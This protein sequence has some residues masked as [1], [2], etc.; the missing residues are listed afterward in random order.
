MNEKFPDMHGMF[1]NS[2]REEGEEELE[3][4]EMLAQDQE[5]DDN[6]YIYKVKRKKQKVSN[7][8]YE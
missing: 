7:E 3:E 1:D 8:D 5:M 6:G 4:G 2:M